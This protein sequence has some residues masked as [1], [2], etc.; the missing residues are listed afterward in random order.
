[1]TCVQVF[2]IESVTVPVPNG[3]SVTQAATR[4]EP[5]ACVVAAAVVAVLVKVA[6]VEAWPPRASGIA[7]AAD[8][9]ESGA[10]S[11]CAVGAG[12]EAPE[13]PSWLNARGAPAQSG[14]PEL[15]TAASSEPGEG[16]RPYGDAAPTCLR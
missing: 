2:P 15:A 5:V 9:P 6:T 11:A 16:T 8:D 10:V 7:P 12:P 3:L 4:V 13:P 1:M 14:V